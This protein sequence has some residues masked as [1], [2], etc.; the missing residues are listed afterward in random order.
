MPMETF[1]KIEA[2]LRQLE[3]DHFKA[4]GAPEAGVEAFI[5]GAVQFYALDA[6]NRDAATRQPVICAVGV[7]YTSKDVPYAG[8]LYPFLQPAPRVTDVL[9]RE[10]VSRLI[11]AY[12]RNKLVW[13][14]AEPQIE[15]RQPTSPMR[16]YGA[17]NAT[18]RAGLTSTDASEIDDRFIL[19]MTNVC[20][21]ITRKLWQKQLQD[22]RRAGRGASCER[23]VREGSTDH[24]DALFEAVGHCV[25]LWVG[26]SAINGS[27]KPSTQWVWPAFAD[28][29]A[30]NNIRDWL[31]SPNVSSRTKN[32]HFNG[33]FRKRGNRF[34]DWFRP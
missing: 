24:L 5:T 10:A 29:V 32:L 11:S 30:R 34:Y 7:N 4:L 22:A 19:I 9:S 18:A 25:D 27:P 21:F 20:P 8:G 33:A 31:L 28:F 1:G 13:T 3:N 2:A 17:T 26:H 15:K 23:L 16:R 12:N 6:H 14:T